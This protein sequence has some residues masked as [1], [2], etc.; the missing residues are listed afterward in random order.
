MDARYGPTKSA[1]FAMAYVNG[2]IIYVNNIPI[3]IYGKRST[4]I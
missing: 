2:I 4:T 1:Q 3:K